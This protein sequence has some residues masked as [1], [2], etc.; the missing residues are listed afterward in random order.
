MSPTRVTVCLP[1]GGAL[2][3]E[4]LQAELGDGFAVSAWQEGAAPA[5]YA[6]GWQLPPAFWTQ[7]TGLK[8]LFAA[9]AGVDGLLTQGLP[10]GLPLIR[11]EDAGMGAQMAE[12]VLHALL[13]WHRGF[14]RY[15]EQAAQAQWQPLGAPPPKSAWTVG[16]LGYGQLG[17]PVAQA[18]RALGFPVRAWVRSPREA[19]LPLFAGP[20]QLPAF[21]QECRVLVALLPL[22]PQTRGL[23]DAALFARLPRGAYLINVARG[24][25]LRQQDLL[26]ALDRGQLAGAALDVCEPEPAPPDHPFWR[27]PR[28][29]LTPHVAASTLRAEAVAQIGAK[30]RALRRGEAVSGSVGASGY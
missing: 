18:L 7:Q 25:L 1:Q 24:G 5:D 6:L 14:D 3:V 9:G 22:T 21:L 20:Q 15:A 26:E 12:Y 2:W 13:R 17:R 27:H 10:P 23:L 16:L 8:A 19:D 28:I 29:A 4:A 11:L 30:L